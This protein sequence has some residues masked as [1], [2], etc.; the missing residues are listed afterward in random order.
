MR[1]CSSIVVVI[2]LVQTAIAQELPKPVPAPLASPVNSKQGPTKK[3]PRSTVTYRIKNVEAQKLAEVLNQH[4]QFTAEKGLKRNGFIIDSPV[5]IIPEVDSNSLIVCATQEYQKKVAEIIRDVDE[6]PTMV[7]IQVLVEE[8][9]NG[10]ATVLSRPQVMTIDGTEAVVEFGSENK[11]LR[12][13][14]TPHVVHEDEEE[15]KSSP[16]VPR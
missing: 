1:I 11:K 4:L 3:S 7:M 16:S 12:I 2:L 5:V 9:E 15:S 14:F 10:K 13:R 8:I 6:R